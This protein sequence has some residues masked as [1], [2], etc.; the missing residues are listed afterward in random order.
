MTETLFNRRWVVRVNN[1]VFDSLEG[2]VDIAF[3][4]NRTLFSS[5]NVGSVTLFNLNATHRAEI[6]RLRQER[7]RIRVELSAGYGEATPPLLFVGDV[8]GYEDTSEI[9]ETTT[10]IFGV[11]GGVKISEQRFTKTYFENTPL[12]QPIYDLCRALDIGEG[13]ARLIEYRFN[14]QTRLQRPYVMHGLASR[15]LSRYLARLGCS[16]SI[17]SGNIQVLRHGQV[18]RSRGVLLSPETGLVSARYV[19]RRTIEIVSALIPEILPGYRVLVESQRVRGDFRVHA[20]EY[21]GETR[22]EWA[23]K[24]ECRVPRT[25]TPY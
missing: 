5:A 13:N 2:S 24:I 25:T 17:Q 6:A 15:E 8:R 7:R 20:V 11:D 12:A 18:L 14:G 4:V 19:D 3:K 23:C 10:R 9:P 22:G 16:W 1:L 21:F